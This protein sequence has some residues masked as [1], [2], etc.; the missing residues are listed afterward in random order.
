M[1]RPHKR[2]DFAIPCRRWTDHM[3]LPHRV[4]GPAVEKANGTKM[5]LW[6]GHKQLQQDGTSNY[7]WIIGSPDGATFISGP[8]AAPLV[9]YE[10]ED[11]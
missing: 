4:G 2:D 3:G 5:W 11:E 6:H 8:L 9:G 1:R 10:T 7:L